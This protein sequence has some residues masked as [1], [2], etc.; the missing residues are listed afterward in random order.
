MSGAL[1]VAAV[2]MQAQQRAL[3]TIANNIS[4]VNT[5][6]FKRSELRFAELVGNGAG[7]AAGA[8]AQDAI[9]GV[10]WQVRPLVDRQGQVEPTGN[11]RDLAIDG[12]GF[13]E[14]LGP[15]GR[16]LLWRGGAVKVLEDGTL[17]SASGYVLKAGIN[18]PADATEMRI[19]RTG[20]V[21]AVLPDPQG[22]TEIGQI[23]LVRTN[24]L[25][26]LS[27][28]DGGLYAMGDDTAL[29]EAAPGEEG[30]GALVQASLERSNVDLNVEMVGLLISQRAYAANA[31]VLRAADE[32]YA[33]ANGLRR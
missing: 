12:L 27:R 17:A 26:E 33:I 3:D 30:L 6:T 16:S 13:I 5:P 21:F 28:L 24:D 8:A 9:A 14:L 20:K 32:L 1:E 23:N 4:N 25:A 10:G 11:A 31:Q 22:E 19:D 15:G 29:T 2:G 7:Q 18:V